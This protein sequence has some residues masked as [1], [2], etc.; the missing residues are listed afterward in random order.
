MDNHPKRKA[1]R[2][3][4][5]D[6]SQNGAYF[7]TICTKD[8]KSLFGRIV[9]DVGANC[10]RPHLSQVGKIVEAEIMQIGKVYNGVSVDCYVVMPNHVHMIIMLQEAS[11][12][13]RTQFAPTISRIIKQWKGSITKKIGFSPWQKSFHEHIIRNDKSYVKIYEYIENNPARWQEDRYYHEI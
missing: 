1:I 13:G 11:D 3:I 9:N 10:V 8:G 2:L 5:Y 4:E 12:N 7:V 6:Y